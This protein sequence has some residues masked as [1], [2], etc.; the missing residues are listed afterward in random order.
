[1]AL[2]IN[3]LIKE[4]KAML[5]MLKKQMRFIDLAQEKS[6]RLINRVVRRRSRVP[7]LGD[8]KELSTQAGLIAGNLQQYM[9]MLRRGYPT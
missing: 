2:T 3:Q 6:E 8:L 1:M 4:R 7:E 5:R 9:A